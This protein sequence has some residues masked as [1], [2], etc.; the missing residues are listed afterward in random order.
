MR[1]AALVVALALA[2]CHRE[3]A[4]VA[5]GVAASLRDAMPELVT[6]YRR[7][8]GVVVDVTYGA[9]DRLAAQMRHG[10]AFDALV[11]AEAAPLDALAGDQL[12]AADSRRVIASNTIVLV[13][14]SRSPTT[15]ASLATLPPGDKIAIG[16]PASV[17]VGRY[18][19]RYLEQLGAWQAVKPRLVLGGDV[20][21]VLAL[22][23]QGR[24]RV[25]IV[26][27]TDA[28]EAAAL[29]VLDEPSD[30]PTASI[31]AGIATHSPHAA[32]ARAFDEFLGSREGQ[33]ILA[34]YGFAP[35]RD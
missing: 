10:S 2:G 5:V 25:A 20:A 21:G 17:P 15:F 9:S 13:G 31:V 35:P 29:A 23:M 33:Q 4:H 11:L 30:A 18:A 6:A 8:T 28:R 19:Q 32:R 3:P 16:D 7:Q 24:A 1:L 27:R 34:R 26:Y 22:A 14:P 12:I